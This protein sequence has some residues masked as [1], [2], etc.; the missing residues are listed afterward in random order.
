MQL[1]GDPPRHKSRPDSST[2]SDSMHS[3]LSL[4]EQQGT[5]IVFLFIGCVQRRFSVETHT[6]KL[7]KRSLCV[8]ALGWLAGKRDMSVCMFQVD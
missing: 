3:V 6:R 8:P 1:F 7:C 2:D 5:C 4:Q